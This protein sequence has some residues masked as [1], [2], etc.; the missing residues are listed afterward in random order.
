MAIAGIGGQ[1]QDQQG[2]QTGTWEQCGGYMSTRELM[3]V[4]YCPVH[5]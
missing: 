5:H 3:K 4:T 2:G 1:V